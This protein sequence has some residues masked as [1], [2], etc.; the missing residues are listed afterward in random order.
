[1]QRLVIGLLFALLSCSAWAELEVITL[2]HRNVEDVLPVVRPLLDKDGVASGMNNQ[3]ILRTSP[4]NLAEIRKLLDSIDIAPRRL[5]ITVLQDVDSETVKRL[6]EVSGSVGVGN[7]GRVSVPG[8]RNNA[9]LTVEAGQG[10][11]RVRG[12]IYSTRSLADDKKQQQVMV[13]EG[14]RALIRTG[15]SVPVQQRQVV[16]SPWQTQV[17]DS[18]EYRDVTSGFYVLPRVSGDRVTLE[19]TAQNDAQDTAAGEQTTR[20]QNVS[21]TVSG[22]LGEWLV[23][24][25]ISQQGSDDSSTISAHT[26]SRQQERRNVLLK[27]EEVQ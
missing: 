4:R 25:D 3:L 26:T 1:M 22:R 11:D 16:T 13:L 27:V 19:V 5:K 12:R 6:T 10:A 20:L 14:N 18:T 17:I 23:L 15:Q 7:G 21:T 9:G 2:Q 24:G 8:S